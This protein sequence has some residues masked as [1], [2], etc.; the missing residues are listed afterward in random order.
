MTTQK[1]PKILAAA[2]LGLP[3]LFIAGTA[4]AAGSFTFPAGQ[5]NYTYTS[6]SVSIYGSVQVGNAPS[7]SVSQN[8]T[9]NLAVIG[10]SGNAPTAKVTQTGVLNVAHITQI[11]TSTNALTIQF[12][13]I[14]SLLGQ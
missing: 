11:G 2:L 6:P 4:S 14:E 3:M 12:G 10:Q 1:P 9:H 13:N 7:A 5:V 8:S